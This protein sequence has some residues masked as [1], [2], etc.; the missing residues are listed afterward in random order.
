MFLSNNT[1]YFNS[2]VVHRCMSRMWEIV[3]FYTSRSL[4][5]TRWLFNSPWQGATRLLVKVPIKI[6]ENIQTQSD[7]L[8]MN[9]NVRFSILQRFPFLKSYE[10]FLVN[11]A[12]YLNMKSTSTWFGL[13]LSLELVLFLHEPAFG[14]GKINSETYCGTFSE[15][16]YRAG[17]LRKWTY[18]TKNLS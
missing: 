15:N 13:F 9:T 11:T 1:Q 16:K 14:Y 12:Y 8:E 7:M 4:D 3:V 10:T 18:W 5:L 6:H 17:I 2:A